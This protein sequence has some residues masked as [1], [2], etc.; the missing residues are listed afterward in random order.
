MLA[1]DGVGLQI[2]AVFNEGMHDNS[3]REKTL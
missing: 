2:E 3:P 1:Y